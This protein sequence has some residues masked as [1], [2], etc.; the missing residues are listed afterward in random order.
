MIITARSDP[1]G[2]ADGNCD[3]FTLAIP[4]CGTHVKCMS[5]MHL[6]VTYTFK[7]DVSFLKGEVLFDRLHPSLPPDVIVSAEDDMLG[8]HVDLENIRVC[9]NDLLNHFAHLCYEHVL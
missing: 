5:C 8:F 9:V 1:E 7:F 6:A 2:P 4:Y 3:R